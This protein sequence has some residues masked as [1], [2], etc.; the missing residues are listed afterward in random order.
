[1]LIWPI[2][3]RLNFHMHQS[4]SG[5]RWNGLILVLS[6]WSPI[7]IGMRLLGELSVVSCRVTMWIRVWSLITDQPLVTLIFSIYLTQ[8]FMCEVDIELHVYTTMGMTLFSPRE[9]YYLLS[10]STPWMFFSFHKAMYLSGTNARVYM[11]L[12]RYKQ[13]TVLHVIVS[14]PM[15]ATL[16]PSTYM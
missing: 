1:M 8:A 5:M 13:E 4:T 6:C 15:Q 9:L 3:Y 11:F 10:F 14:V 16:R 12:S 2:L 7:A